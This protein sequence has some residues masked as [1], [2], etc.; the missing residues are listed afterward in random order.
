MSSICDS[1]HA[2]CCRVYRLII[3][4]YDFLDLV[5]H[6]GLNEAVNGVNFEP[7]PFNENYS[8][9]RNMMFPFIFDDPD[10]KGKMFSLA[11]KRV[12]S[13]LFPGT[14]KC[15]FLTEGEREQIVINPEL[16]NHEEHLGS[17]FYGRCS[18]YEG[19]P[20]MCRTY[21]IAFNPN[22]QRSFIQKREDNPKAADDKV[23]KICPK[24]TV[25]LADFGITDQKTMLRKNDE[26]L[27][28]HART[29]AHNESVLRWNSQPE[30]EIKNVVPYMLNVGKLAI[31]EMKPQSN[32]IQRP[33]N[34]ETNT[35]VAPPIVSI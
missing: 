11:L 12:E 29:L 14:L 28:N 24:P 4:I 8:S 6:V 13:K 34:P 32:Q 5:N 25:G 22:L 19:R 33:L 17:R 3:T 7:S 26:A 16:P 9:N 1:C 15:H 27:L 30:R 21:P 18:V 2:G 35:K 31:A 10:R 20:T 23:L